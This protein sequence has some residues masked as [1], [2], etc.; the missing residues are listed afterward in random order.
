MTFIGALINGNLT[1]ISVLNAKVTIL[2]N[3]YILFIINFCL[4]QCNFSLDTFECAL[5]KVLAM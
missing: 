4:G 5:N 2:K 1:G 3:I